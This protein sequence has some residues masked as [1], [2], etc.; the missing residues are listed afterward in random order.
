MITELLQAGI[1][2]RTVMGRAGHASEAMT[3]SVYGKVRPTADAAAADAWGRN[4]EA[5]VA[6]LRRAASEPH[7]DGPDR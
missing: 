2:P 7:P 6:E 4:L 5:K 3:M 1:D